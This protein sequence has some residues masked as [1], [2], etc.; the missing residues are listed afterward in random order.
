MVPLKVPL[1][2]RLK[3][4]LPNPRKPSPQLLNRRL[5]P[6]LPRLGLPR[7]TPWT[8]TSRRR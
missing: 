4:L 5:C 8:P 2:A 3:L 1:K 6:R 7:P